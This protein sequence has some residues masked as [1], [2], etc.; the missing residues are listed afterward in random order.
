MELTNR[1]KTIIRTA[2]ITLI[3]VA[4]VV[5]LIC[6]LRCSDST[7]EQPDTATQI[8]RIR[9]Q[10]LLYVLTAQVEDFTQQQATERHLGIFPEQHSCALILRQKVSFTVNMDSVTYTP[11]DATHVSVKLPDPVYQASTQS[12]VFTS[13]DEEF[14]RTNMPTT[15]KMKQSGEQQIRKKYDTPENRQ[16]ARHNAEEAITHILSQIGF[17]PVFSIEKQFEE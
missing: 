17:V 15:K 14:W 13:D 9:P 12:S 8:E 11:L 3:V 10:G 2:G 5:A 7:G 6:L 16:Q 1:D 4:L